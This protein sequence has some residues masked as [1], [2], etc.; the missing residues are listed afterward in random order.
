MF[1]LGRFPLSCAVSSQAYQHR[2][3][4]CIF[5]IVRSF[6]RED[7]MLGLSKASSLT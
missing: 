7:S 1:Q 3:S 5:N 4:S 2:M 6:K